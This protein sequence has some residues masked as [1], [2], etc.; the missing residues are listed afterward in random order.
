MGFPILS[1]ICFMPILTALIVFFIPQH[2]LRALKTVP[3]VMMGLNLILSLYCFISYDVAA[4]GF[5]FMEKI[6][7]VPDLG[8]NYIMAVDGISMPLVLL[9]SMIIFAGTCISFDMDDRCLLYTSP[10]PRD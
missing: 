5:Q 4:G 7:V 3:I 2:N 6:A 9:T 10:S 1:A 8:I